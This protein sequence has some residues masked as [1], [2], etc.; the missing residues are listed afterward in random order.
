MEGYEAEIWDLKYRIDV[1]AMAASRPFVLNWIMKEKKK[2]T[3]H[4]LESTTAIFHGMNVLNDRELLVQF[5][6]EYVSH[7]D[8]HGK[9]VG[10]AN[11]KKIVYHMEL[12]P[13]RLQESIVPIPFRGMRE[14]GAPPFSTGHA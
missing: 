5:C 7:Y 8:V 3:T 2:G 6:D 10:M 13:Y 12:T 11:F 4:P 14:D 9:L 1:A